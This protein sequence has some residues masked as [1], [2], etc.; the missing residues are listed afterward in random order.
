MYI[1]PYANLLQR[2]AHFAYRK[3]VGVISNLRVWDSDSEATKASRTF[4]SDLGSSCLVARP[5]A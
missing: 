5:Q 4:P 1:S 3:H 2:V